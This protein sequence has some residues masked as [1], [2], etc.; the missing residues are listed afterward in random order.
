MDGW[1]D[2]QMDTKNLNTTEAAAASY[3]RI[4]VILL[5]LLCHMIHYFPGIFHWGVICF[6][7]PGHLSGMSS[8]EETSGQNADISDLAWER[9]CICLD[10]RVEVVGEGMLWASPLKELPTRLGTR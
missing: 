4:L 5:N 2:G 7:L 1:L 3:K 10:V 6:H 9:L 8:R